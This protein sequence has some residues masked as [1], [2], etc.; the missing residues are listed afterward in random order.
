MHA[1]C[2]TLPVKGSIAPC[3]IGGGAMDFLQHCQKTF[4]TQW[5]SGSSTSSKHHN[6]RN[7]SKT[8]TPLFYSIISRKRIKESIPT[9]C[10]QHACATISYIGLT[11]VFLSRRT[12]QKDIECGLSPLGLRALALFDSCERKP[13]QILG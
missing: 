8:V 11:L 12:F 9:N 7:N 4:W 5:T 10:K 1:L 13:W 3:R 2:E 6:S